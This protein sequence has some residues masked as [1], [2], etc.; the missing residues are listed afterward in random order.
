MKTSG[1]QFCRQSNLYSFML[2]VVAGLGLCT[3]AYGQSTAQQKKE[4]SIR[5]SGD[6]KIEVGSNFAGLSF[7]FVCDKING[8]E[9]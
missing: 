5:F 2:L 6:A 9:I 8:E 1:K 4:L 7:P 3:L